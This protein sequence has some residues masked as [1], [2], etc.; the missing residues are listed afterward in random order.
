M[1]IRKNILGLRPK[2][3]S[4]LYNNCVSHI[5][6]DTK[7]DFGLD[8]N[9]RFRKDKPI[10]FG[11]TDDT[12]CPLQVDIG[13]GDLLPKHGLD[14]RTIPDADAIRPVINMFHEA[15]HV[16]QYAQ[17]HHVE[18]PTDEDAYLAVNRLARS[19]NN[20]YY[21][22]PENYF[23]NPREIRAEQAGIIDTYDYLCDIFPDVDADDI[24]NLVLDYVNERAGSD[25]YYYIKPVGGKLFTDI[26]DVDLAF[27]TAFEKS[28]YSQR[29]YMQRGNTDTVGNLLWN[30]KNWSVFSDAF[31]KSSNRGYMQDK[32]VASVNLYLHPE[33]IKDYPVI[34]A[35]GVDLSA[36]ALTGVDF[37]MPDNISF[38]QRG[39]NS[40][41]S[42]QKKER[43]NREL[44]AKFGGMMKELGA[45]DNDMQFE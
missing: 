21:T 16:F 11:Q 45:A 2:D 39:D 42:Y 18:H 7:H 13:V 15:E 19:G 41:S 32:I 35:K 22:Y 25:T 34:Q 40:E 37:Q 12:V 14:F 43:R 36:K 33:Y 8:V 30:D 27:D 1:M 24:E 4:D 31:F 28:K 10:I 20:L 44:D 17:F 9:I 29:M 26:R 3:V 5:C 6:R 23:R 38:L